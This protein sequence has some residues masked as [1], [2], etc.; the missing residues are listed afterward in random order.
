MVKYTPL[1]CSSLSSLICKPVVFFPIYSSSEFMWAVVHYYIVHIFPWRS[2]ILWTK[3]RPGSR[4]RSPCLTYGL[5]PWDQAYK[6]Y[7]EKLL[8][9]ENDLFALFRPSIFL[10]EISIQI[11]YLLTPVLQKKKKLVLKILVRW[12]NQSVTAALCSYGL[13]ECLAAAPVFLLGPTRHFVLFS[14]K[15]CAEIVVHRMFA[16]SLN[17][18]NGKRS[19]R[20][21]EH[22]FSV[23]LFYSRFQD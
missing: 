16:V 11:P 10:S 1:E 7:L 22:F 18:L 23:Y 2:I 6:S 3:R 9:L 5:M 15:I 13:S 4:T 8:K 14:C 21:T 17:G 19:S 20:G 12:F